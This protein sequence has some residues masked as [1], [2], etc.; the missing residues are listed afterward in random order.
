MGTKSL[1]TKRRNTSEIGPRC[2][3]VRS[4]SPRGLRTETSLCLTA[5]GTRLR[6]SLPRPPSCPGYRPCS[7]PQRATARHRFPTTTAMSESTSAHP[8]CAR[9]SPSQRALNP[10]ASAGAEAER[11]GQRCHPSARWAPTRRSTP[12]LSRGRP[13]TLLPLHGRNPGIGGCLREVGC[14]G[15]LRSLAGSPAPLDFESMHTTVTV[16]LLLSRFKMPL[17]ALPF[18]SL[19]SISLFFQHQSNCICTTRSRFGC[20]QDITP[21][22]L[23]LTHSVDTTDVVTW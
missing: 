3:R 18:I 8:A 17:T 16:L 9:P 20:T 14:L 1:Q 19:S 10:P 2:G 7:W 23:K 15:G 22:M 11:A 21:R 4:C 13:S 12:A 6:T 5:R